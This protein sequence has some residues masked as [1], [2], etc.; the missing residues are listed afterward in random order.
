MKTLFRNGLILD[1]SGAEPI[2]G[3]VLIEND[4]IAAVGGEIC[5]DADEIVDAGGLLVCPGLIDAHS[6][7]DFFYDREDAEKYFRPFIEQGITTQVTGNCS[8]SPFGMEPDTPHRE[9]L[10]GGLFDAQHPGSFADFKARAQGNLFVNLVPLIGQGSVRAG[11]T[12]YD[13]TPYTAEQIEKE[14]TY[15]REAMEGGA[16]G[17]GMS[18]RYNLG[19]AHICV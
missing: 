19:E 8:F 13:P 4:R 17:G 5:A 11:L 3:D 1:G 16:F 10:G 12:G 6:H 7:N 14:L 9:K 2:R 18:T 15:V